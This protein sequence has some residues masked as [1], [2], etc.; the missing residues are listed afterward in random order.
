[1]YQDPFH[2][3]L[4]QTAVQSPSNISTLLLRLLAVILILVSITTSFF[5]YYSQKIAAL[6]TDFEGCMRAADSKL[7]ESFPI[8]CVT[9]EGT[10]FVQQLS[11]EQIKLIIPP[12]VTDYQTPIIITPKPDPYPDSGQSSAPVQRV[13]CKRTG[14][15]GQLC[16]PLAADDVYTSCEFLPEFSCYQEATCEI[17]SD[18]QCGFTR[19]IALETCVRE[20]E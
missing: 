2:N 16:V 11:D 9:K 17:Q 14:C 5:Y 18:G 3:E 12:A 20:I 10:V 19:S 4:S 7:R 13:E 15:S 6:P 8:Q 1:M